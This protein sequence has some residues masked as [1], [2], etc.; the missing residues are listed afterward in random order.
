MLTH[1]NVRLS[2]QRDATPEQVDAFC[3]VLP[4]VVRELRAR[5]GL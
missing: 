4:E 1:G 2:L 3:D 5:V